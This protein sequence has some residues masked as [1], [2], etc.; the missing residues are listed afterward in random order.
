[1]ERR[2]LEKGKREMASEIGPGISSPLLE[3]KGKAGV[4]VVLVVLTMVITDGGR[5]QLMKDPRS[6]KI[7][8]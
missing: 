3:E 2:D 4:V 1:M 6:K 8:D 5:S 7:G